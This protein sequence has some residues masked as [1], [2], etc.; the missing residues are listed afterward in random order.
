MDRIQ[1]IQQI[2]SKTNF[3]SYLEIGCHRG[4]SFLPIRAEKKIAVDPNFK[5]RFDRKLKWIARWPAN[6]NNEYFEE[7][8]DAF[9]ANRKDYL[10]KVGPL[11]VILVDG[12]H[13]FRT[14]LNDV[15]GTLRYF[16]PKGLILMH[17]C[18]PPDEAAAFPSEFF[19]TK[20][21][22]KKIKGWNNEWCGDVWKTVV[23]LIKKYPDTLEV[24]VLDTDYGL[25]Y[26]MAKPGFKNGEFKIEENL[27]AEIDRLSYQDMMV[28]PYTTINLKRSTHAGH[29]VERVVSNSK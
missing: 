5:V 15:L 12:L 9:F 25:G 1:I 2:F 17:D 7:T 20:E 16:N 6:R 29:I 27:F 13:N 28:D 3:S 21:E 14:S 19:P 4:K 10:K 26:V 11:D 8:S 24:G 23:Y 18:Y 22:Q